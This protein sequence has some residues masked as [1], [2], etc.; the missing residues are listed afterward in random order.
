MSK[1]IKIM[2]AV[3]AV[4]IIGLSLAAVFNKG[5]SGLATATPI[6]RDVLIKPASHNTTTPDAKVVLVEFGDYQCPSCG[7]AE[8]IIEQIRSDYANNPDFD[9]VF[10]NFPLPQHQNAMIAAEA[11][12]AAA[13]QGKFWEM[14]DLL[15]KNQNDWAE[16]SDQLNI[17]AGYAQQLGLDVN[18]FKQAV[19][20]GQ[21]AGQVEADLNDGE[22]FGVNATPTF[23][24]NGVP[25]VGVPDYNGLKSSI[26]SL[27]ASPSP[28]ASAD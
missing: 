27:L 10:R 3:A 8:P 13:A 26:D 17:F 5:G 25:A 4:V 14:H 21:L 2:L 22:Q 1:E 20:S 23:F 28:S 11:A 15:Y 6:P 16:S 18:A 12:E 19:S 24:L 7:A 9:F